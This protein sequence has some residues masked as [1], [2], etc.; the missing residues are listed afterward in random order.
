MSIVEF[1]VREQHALEGGAADIGT[2]EIGFPTVGFV[3][4]R[5]LQLRLAENGLSTDRST[6]R[7]PDARVIVSATVGSSPDLPT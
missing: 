1:G 6:K 7:L 3:Q 5:A 2:T 4:N